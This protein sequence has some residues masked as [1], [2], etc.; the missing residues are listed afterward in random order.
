MNIL[1]LF[2]F[3]FFSFSL[4]QVYGVDQQLS[5]NEKKAA[6]LPDAFLNCI[7]WNEQYEF[8]RAKEVDIIFDNINQ[9]ELIKNVDENQ[10]K[11][12]IN[13][14]K[15]SL[16]KQLMIDREHY[17]KKLITQY[18]QFFTPDELL[19]LLQYYRT[20]LMQKLVTA[21]VENKAITKE[22]IVKELK[23]LSP[24]DEQAVNSFRNSYIKSRLER[25]QENINQAFEELM[26]E[27]VKEIF[28]T[29]IKELPSLV[30]QVKSNS[31]KGS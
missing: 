13:S 19:V 25:F 30:N 7:K 12:I 3:V 16:I 11:I 17:R 4:N 6:T 26:K 31:T 14:L 9:K 8:Q 29:L 2:F 22:D 15:D 21:K 18:S 1:K 20:K 28:A 24:K 27:R 10:R 5:L 23:E